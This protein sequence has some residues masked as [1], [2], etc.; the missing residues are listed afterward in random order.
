M[1]NDLLFNCELYMHNSI[2][3]LIFMIHAN[4][5]CFINHNSFIVLSFIVIFICY[6]F[7]YHAVCLCVISFYLMYL[8]GHSNN[9]DLVCLDD[10][11]CMWSRK[12]IHRTWMISLRKRK[13]PSNYFRCQIVMRGFYIVHLYII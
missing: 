10:N 1:I 9:L 8:L 3:S 4:I 5:M 12:R 2:V 11:T 6:I 13:E 7:T